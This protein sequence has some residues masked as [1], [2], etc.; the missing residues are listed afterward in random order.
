MDRT[1]TGE[2]D[3]DLDSIGVNFIRLII[4][5]KGGIGRI[6]GE[7][8]RFDYF[9]RQVKTLAGPVDVRASGEFLRPSIRRLTSPILILVIQLERLGG[10]EPIEST[11]QRRTFGNLDGNTSGDK[12]PALH[13]GLEHRR[14]LTSA[15]KPHHLAGSLNLPAFDGCGMAFNSTGGSDL[16]PTPDNAD[17][18]NHGIPSAGLEYRYDAE[19]AASNSGDVEREESC[20]SRR[21]RPVRA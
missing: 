3:V 15:A 12:G 20:A 9:D 6:P 19:I 17:L 18:C 14:L 16:D 2:P 1:V 10:I 5:L 4:Q 13:Q 11:V 8:F 7:E 21:A